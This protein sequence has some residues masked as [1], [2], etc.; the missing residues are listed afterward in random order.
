MDSVE[1][2]IR[3]YLRPV[4][5]FAH[6]FS[7]NRQDAEDISQETFLKVW[8]NIKK[9]REGENFKTWLFAIARNTAIDHLRKKKAL[10]FSDLEKDGEDSI[11]ETLAGA[12]SLEEELPKYILKQLPADYKEIIILKYGND[13]TFDEIAKILNKPLNTVKSQHR[14]ALILLRKFLDNAPK[15]GT[16]PYI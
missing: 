1:K 15:L 12:V 10:V 5:N 9:Y 14:R 6:R 16:R 7:G 11:T 8:K 13:F 2:I 4:Y 3:Q